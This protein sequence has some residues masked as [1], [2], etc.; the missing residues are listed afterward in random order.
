[1]IIAGILESNENMPSIDLINHFFAESNKKIS[2]VKSNSLADLNCSKMK[3]YVRSLEKSNVEILIVGFSYSDILSSSFKYME[4]D[5][6]IIVDKSDVLTHDNNQYY[7]KNAE[8]IE[9]VFPLLNNK[10]IIAVNIDDDELIMYLQGKTYSMITF[11]FNSKA[12]LTASSTGDGVLDEEFICCLQRTIVTQNGN[13]IEP[14]EYGIK[15][16][17]G[18][19]SPYNIMAAAVL[20]IL[21]GSESSLNS[22][23]VIANA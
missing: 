14:Q 17:N 6:L 2:I 3:D 13:I 12:C 5:I 18:D 7:D 11:G 20:E 8:N 19:Y 10:S 15:V 21:T 22:K 16:E 1:M 23:H 9:K 4:F